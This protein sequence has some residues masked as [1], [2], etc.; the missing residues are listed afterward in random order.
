MSTANVDFR[1]TASRR[2]RQ[3]DVLLVVEHA[4]DDQQD[5]ELATIIETL[6]GDVY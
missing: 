1:L 3:D 6:F 2:A 4:V 5:V